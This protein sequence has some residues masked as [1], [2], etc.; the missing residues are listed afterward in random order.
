LGLRLNALPMS[1]RT[2][3]VCPLLLRFCALQRGVLL[4]ESTERKKINI[5]NCSQG[6]VDDFCDTLFQAI[7]IRFLGRVCRFEDYWVHRGKDG[8]VVPIRN[9]I[10]QFLDF[11]LRSCASLKTIEPWMD[12]P[13]SCAIL[14][15]LHSKH[16]FCHF[17]KEVRNS[18]PGLFAKAV[19]GRQELVLKVAD[20]FQNCLPGQNRSLTKKESAGMR[21]MAHLTM[22]DS[23]EI[24]DDP[25]AEV[26]CNSV[27][28]GYGGRV[29]LSLL[30]EAK[31]DLETANS[32]ILAEYGGRDERHLR[33]KGWYKEE[34]S[35][36]LRVILNNRFVNS[37]DVEHDLCKVFMHEVYTHGSRAYSMQPRASKPCC[38][39]LA[40]IHVRLGGTA[41]VKIRNSAL[42]AYRE[43]RESGRKRCSPGVDGLGLIILPDAC[44]IPGE[45]RQI[46]VDHEAFNGDDDFVSI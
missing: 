45:K 22:A 17:I 37:C 15:S 25:F 18:L 42:T 8:C 11:L 1:S 32:I 41:L 40:F 5:N 12:S 19:N 26:T 38:H 3:C 33:I 35:G 20:C 7:L 24:Y 28:P 10:D 16:V 31:N 34:T 6:E 36:R 43:C 2:Y 23:E 46:Y 44:L 21:F 39:P 13:Y 14:S 30:T 9:D 27:H 4:Q 29:G